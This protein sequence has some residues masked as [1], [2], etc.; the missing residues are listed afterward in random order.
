[1]FLFERVEIFRNLLFNSRTSFAFILKALNLFFQ[2][3]SI[4]FIAKNFTESEMGKYY[5]LMSFFGLQ[6]LGDL[7]FTKTMS[8]FL[9]HE[10]SKVSIYNKS[11]KGDIQ[12]LQTIKTIVSIVFNWFIKSSVVLFIVYFFLGIV[13]FIIK[14]HN[15]EIFL[16]WVLL[17]FL[18]CISL[19]SSLVTSFLQGINQIN[20]ANFYASFQLIVSNIL[21]FSTI[22]NFGLHSMLFKML[23]F[24]LVFF[25]CMGYYKNLIKLLIKTEKRNE[26]KIKNLFLNQQRKFALTAIMG[27]FVLNTF[28]PFS[29]YFISSE[30]SGRLGLTL[31]ITST[32]SALM[33]VFFNVNFPLLSQSISINKKNKA[34]LDFMNIIKLIFVF[35][36]IGYVSF[37]IVKEISI[38]K[39]FLNH[40]IL[41]GWNLKL[42][43]LGSIGYL[44]V[45]LLSSFLRLFKTELFVRHSII[46]LILSISFLSTLGLFY[47]KS[48][49]T[50][51][52]FLLALFGVV[53]VS[54]IFKKHLKIE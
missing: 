9:S 26:I 14:E 37:F 46:S 18:S 15:S 42:I 34:L 43:I 6:I 2:L 25:V 7:G 53:N 5:L 13:F 49:I 36:L 10:S 47:Q 19:F 16:L 41:T 17:S 3:L 45:E 54:F 35:T 51:S 38:I 8:I 28:I 39:G 30:F 23:G 22:S 27:F 50:M 12:T 32:F 33:M 11:I 29:Y 31:Q 4:F 20:K 40:K 24:I 44:Y 52:Y 21:F 1:M 48:G